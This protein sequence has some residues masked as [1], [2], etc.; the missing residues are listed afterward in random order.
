MTLTYPALDAARQ[1]L[2]LVT[3][4]D[5]REPLAKLLAGDTSIPAGRVENDNDDRSSPTRPPPDEYEAGGEPPAGFET[6][7][8]DVADGVA[9]I[10]L[11]RP[12]SLN[13]IVPPMPEEVEAAVER[14]VADRGGEG[15]RPPRRR[16][17]LLR[18]L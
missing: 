18:R 8:Y 12:D 1:I 2:W 6:I 13:T 7:L 10:T 16:A 14:A 17:R 9:T 11:N 5:K 3:G 15:D 4:A